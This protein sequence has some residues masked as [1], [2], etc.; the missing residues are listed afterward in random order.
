MF[1]LCDKVQKSESCD[2]VMT[3]YDIITNTLDDVE[4]IFYEDVP[5]KVEGSGLCGR[6]YG[7]LPY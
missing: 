7:F 2:L 1:L 3:S 5:M 4:V 6:L